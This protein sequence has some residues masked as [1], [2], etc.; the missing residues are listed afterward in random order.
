MIFGLAILFSAFYGV[1]ANFVDT[2]EY[3]G[4]YKITVKMLNAVYFL[5]FHFLGSLIGWIFLYCLY[6]RIKKLFPNVDQLKLIDILLLLFGFLGITGHLPQTLYGFV[7]SFGKVAE[8]IANK[9]AFLSIPASQLIRPVILRLSKPN[10]TLTLTSPTNSVISSLNFSQVAGTPEM[11][12]RPPFQVAEG[13]L[14]NCDEKLAQF[15][16]L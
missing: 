6:V 12:L 15:F 2:I 5:I 10:C 16:S 14:R 1:R 9:I 11:C 4:R 8:S 13:F 7:L 3:S